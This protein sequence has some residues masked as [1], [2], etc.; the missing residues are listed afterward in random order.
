MES[1]ERLGIEERL[2]KAWREVE[3]GDRDARVV[4]QTKVW[5]LLLDLWKSGRKSLDAH[6]DLSVHTLGTS[7]EATILAI[8]GIRAPKVVILHTDETEKYLEKIK[9]EADP[10]V[11]IPIRVEKAEV[12]DIYRHAKR[13]VTEEMDSKGRVA[14]DITS[15]TKAMTAGLAA[16]GFYI[17]ALRELKDAVLPEIRVYYVDSERYSTE[18][19]RPVAGSE[20][21]VELISP[22]VALDE[23]AE[24]RARAA[25][26][27]FNFAKAAREFEELNQQAYEYEGDYRL[28]AQLSAAYARWLSFDF[29]GAQK[30]LSGLVQFLASPKAKAKDVKLRVHL[31]TL[32]K[33]LDQL[34]WI[35]SL[36]SSCKQGRCAEDCFK[37]INDVKAVGGLLRT[38]EFLGG[39][40]WEKQDL[41]MTALFYYRSLELVIQHLMAR[42]GHN[43]HCFNEAN[44]D[45]ATREKFVELARKVFDDDPKQ[46]DSGRYGLLGGLLFLAALD[47]PV[48]GSIAG[49][50][51]QLR[52]L[53][54]AR[55]EAVLI[56]GYA[57]P[58]KSHVKSL[59]SFYHG[60]SKNV[61]T[62]I[63]RFSP[64]NLP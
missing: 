9:K 37:Q 34:N 33:Q 16:A 13:I 45:Q 5:P 35:L 15:G 39:Q 31:D 12:F 6:F 62:S 44:L 2:K 18:A 54:E 59:K 50:L 1:A 57:M 43:I 25:Y 53:V 21:L 19:R 38:L 20:R 60:L 27:A 61:L 7:P 48:V 14:F 42:R 58:S 63:P 4:Y 46:F 40:A 10:K 22:F 8:L 24:E 55:N 32:Q 30:K 41:V 36:Q 29:E 11:L 23:L 56:H 17:Q 28:Y 3:K 49:K 52:A 51:K 26:K 47:D 64:V